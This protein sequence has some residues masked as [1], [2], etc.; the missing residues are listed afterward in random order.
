MLSS[1][2]IDIDCKILQWNLPYTSHTI[3]ERDDENGDVIVLCLSASCCSIFCAWFMYSIFQFVCASSE[4]QECQ[5]RQR[6]ILVGVVVGVCAHMCTCVLIHRNSGI[7]FTQR[8]NIVGFTM[9]HE[10]WNTRHCRV[11]M[12][13]VVSRFRFRILFPTPNNDETL[14]S[15]LS[16]QQH[17]KT[18]FL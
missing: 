12:L 1:N 11:Y 9:R 15:T 3:R 17:L 6:D 8:F 2:H 16:G 10:S 7:M 5:P 18:F 14:I 4:Q 13:C